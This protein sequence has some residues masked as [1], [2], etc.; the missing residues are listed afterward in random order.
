MATT[1]GATVLCVEEGQEQLQA[2]KKS[3]VLLNA[4]LLNN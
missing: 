2:E 3:F 1:L 4:E